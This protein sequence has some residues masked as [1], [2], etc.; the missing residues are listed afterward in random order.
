ME[1]EL[2][3]NV[4]LVIFTALMIAD[5]IAC[6]VYFNSVYQGGGTPKIGKTWS[7]LMLIFSI[8]LMIFAFF[9]F[10]WAIVRIFRKFK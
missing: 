3:F 4:I 10:M 6:I 7:L 9:I 2:V 1:E 8:I 5:S